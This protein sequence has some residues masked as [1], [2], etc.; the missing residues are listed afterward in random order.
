[1]KVIIVPHAEKQLLKLPRTERRKIQKK[2]LFLKIDPF[3]GKKLR[4]E[5][6]GQYGVRAW[7]YRIIYWINDKKKVVY[8]I[9]IL[10]RQGAYN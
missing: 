5:F 2:L 8:V 10:H 6:E 9:S 4:G 7:P 3:I 1:M